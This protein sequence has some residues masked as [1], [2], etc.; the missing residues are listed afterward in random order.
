MQKFDVAIIGG[1]VA[2]LTAAV[3][4]ARA[5]K[6]TIVIEKQERLGG[7][8]MTNKKDG[9]YFNLGGHALYKGDAY[10]TFREFGLTLKGGKPSIDAHGIWQ[11]EL[12]VLPTGIGSLLAS[13]LFTWKGKL[14]FVG[15]LAKFPKLDTHAYDAISLRDWIE[16]N[17]QDPMVRHVFYSLL[18][19]ASYVMAPD[20]Q[21]AGPILRQLANALKGVL[22]L[23]EGWGAMMDELE[24]KARQYGVQF[25]TKLKAAAVEHQD[26]VVKG[27]SFED[28]TRIEADHV[29]IAAAPAV[30]CKLVPH[31]D[32]TSLGVWKEQAI[33]VTAACLDVALRKLTKPKQQFVYGIDRPVFLTNQSRASKLSDN[34]AQVVCVIKYQ[35][36]ETDPEKDLRELESTLDLVQ[37]G[38]RSELASKQ[39]LPKIT[40]CHDFLHVRG[41]VNPGPD[42][43]EI[44]GLYVA[45]DWASHGELLVDA[46]TA[47]ARRAVEHLL[48]SEVKERNFG[49]GYRVTV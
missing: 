5:G 38:W 19:T 17:I 48:A 39:F 35:G 15:W 16:G 21:A 28:G 13:P 44:K 12:S 30:A 2:G 32:G 43:P 34:G 42:V 9:T 29:I 8:A 47:S 18:R 37:P 26:G 45:G 7:R 6:K 49:H 24:E 11:G 3:L 33:E 10:D 1:G 31:A 36:A 27:V 40:V 46:A 4:A 14:E 23:D 22:Y 41:R 20:L 25:R